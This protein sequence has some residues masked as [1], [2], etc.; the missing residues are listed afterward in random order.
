MLILFDFE[1]IQNTHYQDIKQLIVEKIGY[2]D[3]I[4]AEKFGAVVEGNENKCLRDWNSNIN[5]YTAANHQQAADDKL[6]EIAIKHHGNR[7]ILVSN[8]CL[9]FERIRKARLDSRCTKVTSRGLTKTKTYQILFI[10]G[11][12]MLQNQKEP[13]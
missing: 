2:T 6:V 8:D 7:C 3:W 1:N 10:D 9:L 4:K 12:L 13:L 5:I 11:V